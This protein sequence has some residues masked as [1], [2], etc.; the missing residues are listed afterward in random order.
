MSQVHAGTAGTATGV[1][2]ERLSRLVAIKD[3]LEIAVGEKHAAP[4]QDMRTVAGD[5]LEALQE[6]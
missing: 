4:K 6:L 5:P 2:K 3:P 1:E